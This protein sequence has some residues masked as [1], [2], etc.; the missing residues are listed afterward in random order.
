MIFKCFPEIS[1]ISEVFFYWSL[2][3]Y[4][5]SYIFEPH[6][7]MIKSSVAKQGYLDF[8]EIYVSLLFIHIHVD[9][10]PLEYLRNT[11]FSKHILNKT[12]Q[13]TLLLLLTR[14]K[15]PNREQLLG[16]MWDLLWAY[17]KLVGSAVI[18]Q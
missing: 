18:H 14:D 11:F 15:E 16:K 8:S 2:I 12:E 9:L 4:Q 5:S 17:P 10:V 7:N 3:Y 6:V 1:Q 13:L